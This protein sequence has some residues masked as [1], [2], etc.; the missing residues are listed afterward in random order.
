M[1]CGYP[2]WS[3]HSIDIT[4]FRVSKGIGILATLF[5][6]YII[7]SQYKIGG[8]RQFTGLSIPIVMFLLMLVCR[9]ITD[10]WFL[11]YNHPFARS[12]LQL[13]FPIMLLAFVLPMNSD[14]YRKGFYCVY[15]ALFVLT[16]I[17]LFTWGDWIF[18][19]YTMRSR[20]MTAA[21]YKIY[22]SILFGKQLR[23]SGETHGGHIGYV[24]L[25]GAL[26][27]ALSL[28]KL[29]Q[30]K[31]V[32]YSGQILFIVGY[33]LGSILMFF[34]AYRGIV[35]GFVTTFLFFTCVSKFWKSW[36]CL[37]KIIILLSVTI[38]LFFTIGFKDNQ[39][40]ISQ[41][42]LVLYKMLIPHSQELITNIVESPVRES[43][44]ALES[45]PVISQS[46][47]ESKPPV[48]KPTISK[49]LVYIPKPYTLK[50]HPKHGKTSRY[51]V[52]ANNMEVS[53][54]RIA[55]YLICIDLIRDN[56]IVGY[57]CV[58]VI[59]IN[60]QPT[61]AT[62]H[63]NILTAFLATGLIGG[64]LFL[65][66]IIRGCI[67][68]FVIIKYVPECGWLAAIFLIGFVSNITDTSFIEYAPLWV[69]LVAMRACVK[70]QIKPK[71]QDV[72]S[73]TK[74]E[75]VKQ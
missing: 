56:P 72:K 47:L 18:S 6:A 7:F 19:G 30:Q 36:K 54:A 16:A 28:Y 69:P 39:R 41:R 70:T 24:G 33:I 29:L 64:C 37:A 21:E 74:I 9:Q 5:F 14:S 35:L 11:H 34:A 49:P 50:E 65:Y 60:D 55:Q 43:E 17:I 27:A 3:Y 63:C 66:I 53:D 42:F 75:E 52:L 4:A 38:I 13:A 71:L 31:P 2:I 48:S 32:I 58:L 15:I 23:E 67:D 10:I 20:E 22:D 25:L 44:S 59:N 8:F 1:L 26:L 51:R 46:T 57:G 62:I 45:K 61:F 40:S 73:E 68:S 12:L